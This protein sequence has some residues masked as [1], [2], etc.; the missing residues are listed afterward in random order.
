MTTYVSSQYI[1]SYRLQHELVRTAATT[2]KA[3]ESSVLQMSGTP[4]QQWTY[5]SDRRYRKNL[6]HAHDEEPQEQATILNPSYP[7]QSPRFLSH[8]GQGPEPAKFQNASHSKHL[9]QGPVSDSGGDSRYPYPPTTARP[10]TH[11]GIQQPAVPGKLDYGPPLNAHYETSSRGRSSVSSAGRLNDVDSQYSSSTA[12]FPS[13]VHSDRSPRVYAPKTPIP[14]YQMPI[15]QRQPT[16]S[17]PSGFENLLHHSPTPSPP[18]QPRTSSLFRCRLLIR[19]Q[20]ERARA[21]GA[22]DRDRRPVDPPPIIQM[23]LTD[24]DLR[25]E[26]DKAILQDPRFTVGCLLYPVHESRWRGSS[27]MVLDDS[28]APGQSTPLLSG[29]TFVSPFYVDE[30][31]DPDTALAHP[32]T[33]TYRNDPQ[34]FGQKPSKGPQKQPACFFIFSDLSVRTA[35]TYRLQ[36]RLM[37]WGSVEDTG[38]VV[39][40]LAEAWSEP[41]QVHAAKDFPGM[42]ESSPLAIRLKEL[43][44]VELKTRGKGIGKGRKPGKG[45]LKSQ[46]H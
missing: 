26:D 31:P 27:D 7:A 23:L 39:P 13:P 36:F 45:D 5:V 8:H 21:C 24:F 14:S 15:H 43:G 2:A 1:D 38:Q 17:I 28:N 30:D 37:N 44:F 33:D 32:Q 9:A 19:Q 41:F 46:Q 22:G 29:K 16:A 6:A 35:G 34:E 11:Y 3:C 20:P 42:K 4:F 25:S 40:V 12:T 10:L 18:P